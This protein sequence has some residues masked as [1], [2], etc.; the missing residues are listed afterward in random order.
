MYRLEQAA[1]SKDY[2]AVTKYV[3]SKRILEQAED[4]YFTKNPVDTNLRLQ[5]AAGAKEI[6]A[7]DFRKAIK[8][9]TLVKEEGGGDFGNIVEAFTKS[10]VDYLGFSS[11]LA[12]SG[13]D[14]QEVKLVRRGLHWVVVEFKE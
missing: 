7:S 14:P 12:S 4:D 1:F 2:D 11:V 3:D 10:D 13:D 6:V 5:Y 9:G 8:N